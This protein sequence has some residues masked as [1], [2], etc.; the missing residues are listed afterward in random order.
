MRRA[1]IILITAGALVVSTAGAAQANAGT[2]MIWASLFQL[3]IGNFF[4]GIGEGYLLMLRYGTGAFRSIMTM[5]IANYVSAW[6][7]IYVILYASPKV[8]EKITG[9]YASRLHEN[10]A[11]ELLLF[12]CLYV[13]TIIIEWPFCY[14]VQLGCGK[15]EKRVQALKALR[16]SVLVQTASYLLLLPLYVGIRVWE[17][18][19]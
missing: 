19:W 18:G 16:A 3:S 8:L 12:A 2:M 15:N 7:G 17:A 11:S 1:G 14:W 4:I 9:D 6:L 10:L 13:L 5:I